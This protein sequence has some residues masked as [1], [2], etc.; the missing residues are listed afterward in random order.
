MKASNLLITLTDMVSYSG[1][2]KLKMAF[3]TPK[4]RE[5]NP[6]KAY[7]STKITTTKYSGWGVIVLF[8]A[9]THMSRCSKRHT[10][11]F[12]PPPPPPARKESLH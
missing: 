1:E 5:K 4:K 11:L 10:I 7:I 3:L 6:K 9:S 8:T 2:E 12:P